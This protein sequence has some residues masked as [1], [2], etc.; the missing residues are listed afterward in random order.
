MVELYPVFREFLALLASRRVEYLLVGGYAVAVHGYTRYTADIDVWIRVSEE[1]AQRVFAAVCDFGFGASDLSPD[2]FLSEGRMTR[3]GRPPFKIEI[4]N[5]VSGVEFD[6]AAERSIEVRIDGL[7]VPVI[8]LADLRTNKAA[9]GRPKDLADLDNLPL[10][11]H[12][13]GGSGA[14][15]AAPTL[16][17]REPPGGGGGAASD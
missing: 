12:A 13:G 11:P 5:A 15:G 3:I 1:N 7:T 10:P 2:L 4:L 8:S 14:D 9:S 16:E 17:R 6:A